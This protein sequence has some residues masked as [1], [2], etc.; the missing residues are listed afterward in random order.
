MG[1]E[2]FSKEAG[3]VALKA[4]GILAIVALGFIVTGWAWNKWIA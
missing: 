3:T 2:S 4:A 1:V